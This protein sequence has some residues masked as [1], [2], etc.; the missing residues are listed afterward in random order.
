MGKLGGQLHDYAGG[1]DR[2]PV[3]SR[4]E[5]EM[6]KSVGNGTTFPKNLTTQAQVAAGIGLLADSVASRLRRAGLYAGGVHVTVR[7]PAFHDRSRQ[8]QLAAPTHLIREISA[9][10]L[11][12]AGELWKPPSPVRALTVTAIH[13]TPEG[14]TYEQADLFTAGSVL[15][16]KRQERL[17]AAMDGIRRRYGS[18]SIAFG[19]AKP[20]EG[21]GSFQK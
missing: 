1:L 19:T 18:S 13:L 9:A 10:A 14:E 7:D 15:E 5:P 6:V 12:L 20:E 17:E 3:R 4:H 16:R 8:R 11:E 2:E 21:G